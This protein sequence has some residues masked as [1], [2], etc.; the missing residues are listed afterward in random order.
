V[1]SILNV[2]QLLSFS[3]PDMA[4]DGMPF[5]Q[6]TAS[7]GVKN[8]ILTTQDFFIDSNVMHVTTVGTIDI[9]KETLDMLIGVQPLQTVDRI[10]SRVPVVGWILSGGDGSLITTYFEAKGSWENPEVTAIPV[11]TMAK[12]TLDI[13]RR[14]FELPVR[15]FTDS[16]EVILG[17][18]KERP[19]AGEAPTQ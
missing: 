2:S 8:G 14:V 16:G 18:Q 9:V 12:G 6:I 15:L 11:K 4:R 7:I 3:L 5:N 10:V 17:N 1:I 13:F 19:K